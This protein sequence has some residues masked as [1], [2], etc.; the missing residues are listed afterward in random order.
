MSRIS[1]L[2]EE[3]AETISRGLQLLAD[4][5]LTVKGR[6]VIQVAEAVQNLG[7]LY[8]RLMDNTLQ[9]INPAEEAGPPPE[10]SEDADG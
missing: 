5:D 9:L 8:N 3:A 1:K 4:A 2:N 10:E 6:A 7:V